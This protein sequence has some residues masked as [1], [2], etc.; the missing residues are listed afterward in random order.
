MPWVSHKQLTWMLQKQYINKHGSLSGYTLDVLKKEIEK[1]TRRIKLCTLCEEN[2]CE[3]TS[4]G[5]YDDYTHEY[6]YYIED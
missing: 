1:H 2:E 4:F 5:L 3:C 6:E